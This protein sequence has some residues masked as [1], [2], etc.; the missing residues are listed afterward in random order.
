MT[1]QLTLDAENPSLHTVL[2]S[3]GLTTRPAGHGRKD[4]MRGEVVVLEAATA[5]EVWEWLRERA[6][7]GGERT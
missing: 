3:L 6:T 2:R 7:K 4:I 5:G 1:S